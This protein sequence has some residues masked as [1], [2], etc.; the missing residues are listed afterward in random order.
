MASSAGKKKLVKC[1]C[2]C[3][4]RERI[5]GNKVFS[6]ICQRCRLLPLPCL[7]ARR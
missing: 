2:K 4:C 1:R 5:E 6:P 7:L 3:K